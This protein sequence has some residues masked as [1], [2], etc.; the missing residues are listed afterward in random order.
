ESAMT[1]D[2]LQRAL[3]IGKDALRGAVQ[4]G[5]RSVVIG[6]MGIGNTTSA[7]ALAAA[8]LQEEAK[9][10]VGPGTGVQ[11]AALEAKVQRVEE[12]LAR[13][14]NERD[15]QVLLRELGGFEI[16]AMTGVCL[17][18]VDAHVPVIVDGFISS[19][20]ALC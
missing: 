1:N 13:V 15:A 3:D 12:A 16:A 6:E 17:A 5:N 2:Q 11:G 7:S 4:R 10:L 9:L 18:S 20:A 14:P 19:V 8:L